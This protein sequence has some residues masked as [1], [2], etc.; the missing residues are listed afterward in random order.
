MFVVAGGHVVVGG[1]DGSSGRSLDDGSEAWSDSASI[2][3]LNEAGYAIEE[4]DGKLLVAA[5]GDEAKVIDPATGR[6]VASESLSRSY[7]I[8]VTAGTLYATDDHQ[9]VAYRGRDLSRL[10]SVDIDGLGD[11]VVSNGALFV[12][13]ADTVEAFG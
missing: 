2:V 6:S 7:S 8:D 4:L 1:D 9:V 12:V 10:W 3:K 11:T 5:G 13:S